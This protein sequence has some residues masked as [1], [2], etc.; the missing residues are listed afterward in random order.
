MAVDN[1]SVHL[2]GKVNLL[3]G[4]NGSGKS[5][6]INLLAGLAFP[7]H[8][9][10]E[11][12]GSEYDAKSKRSWREGTER[13]RK[14]ARFWLDNPGLPQPM[15]GRE[16]LKFEYSQTGEKR[17]DVRTH[18]QELVQNSFGS[19]VDL[20]KP[21]SSYS[22]GMQQKLGIM[23]TLIGEPEFVVWDEPTAT[24]DATSRAIVARLAKDYST[25]GT[26]FLI[27]SHIPGDFEGIADWIGLMRLGQLLK[28]G[29]LS[30]LTI[31]DP[32]FHDYI[33]LTDRASQI[34]SK[35]IDLGFAEAVS[36]QEENHSSLISV[37]ATEEFDE[38]K[39]EDLAKQ[40]GASRL[41]IRRRQK[42]ITE[43]YLDFL[44]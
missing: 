14:K 33:I 23:A 12:D 3:L 20:D 39:V 32:A 30:E 35:L 40:V 1:V 6:L 11:L 27:V 31:S 21:I 38:K 18:L 17:R 26:V 34:A 7:N 4:S 8:G 19:S 15:T 24:L 29:R 10:L 28:S 36:L 2:T 37:K 25:K 5:T 42:S 41:N 9:I 16:L 13:I 43:L 22:T 44:G